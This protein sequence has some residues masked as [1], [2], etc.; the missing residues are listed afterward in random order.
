MNET[1]PHCGSTELNRK[2]YRKTKTLG[3][4]PIRRCRACK[5]RFT[6]QAIQEPSPVTPT[7]DYAGN[8]E[9]LPGSAW[10]GP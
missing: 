8:C 4:R 10:A 3:K 6:L 9:S 2:G 7:L 1:C 5:R